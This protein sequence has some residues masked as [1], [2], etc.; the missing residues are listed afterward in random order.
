MTATV[1]LVAALILSG[2]SVGALGDA[3]RGILNGEVIGGYNTPIADATISTS[4]PTR[5]V[6]TDSAGQF[7]ITGIEPRQYMVTV[8]RDSTTFSFPWNVRDRMRPLT[9]R[10]PVWQLVWSDEFDGVDIDNSR[11]VVAEG[12]T[13]ITDQTRLRRDA[14][15]VRDGF[16]RITTVPD[17]IE[18]GFYTGAIITTREK[19]LYGRF[20]VR[21]KLP[22]GQGL[23]PAHWL[24]MDHDAPEID[25]MEALG[26]DPTRVYTTYHYGN[27]RGTRRSRSSRVFGADRS[28][29]Y[30]V[31]ALEWYPDEAIW[32]IDGEEVNRT[33]MLQANEP[34][35][36]VI[37]T[38]VGGTWGGE[39]DEST[40]FPQYHDVDYVRIWQSKY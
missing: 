29:A 8:A 36:F 13:G 40:V 39:V 7:V 2:C 17:T 20:E 11:W 14:V 18:P 24:W 22:S 16:L 35:F 38:I 6:T 10:L 19:F 21:A 31:Y 30:H 4:P 33:P 27:H 1:F 32:F 15:T 9:V 34:L 25:I 26:D 5:V 12:R 23:W 3:P 28:A 37:D